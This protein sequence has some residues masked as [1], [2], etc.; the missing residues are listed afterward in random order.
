MKGLSVSSS[1]VVVVVVVVL[2]VVAAKVLP[3]AEAVTC[4]ATELSPCLG[5]ITSNQAPSRQCCNKLNEQRP[6]LCGY[7]KNPI[8]RPYVK[9]AGALR[10]SAAC[11]I[12][13]P[14]CG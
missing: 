13:T 9:S 5:A 12:P 10:V 6:C 2:T 4:S 7:I 14:N 3:V 11:R 8:L 1:M